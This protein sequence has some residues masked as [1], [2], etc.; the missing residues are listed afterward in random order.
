MQKTAKLMS[1]ILLLSFQRD[2]NLV[3]PEEVL[4]VTGG[5]PESV[6]S[7]GGSSYYGV[8]REI[9]IVATVKLLGD[10]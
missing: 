9:W 2:V 10:V 8:A 7:F 6:V 1:A 4:S 5:V 3:S